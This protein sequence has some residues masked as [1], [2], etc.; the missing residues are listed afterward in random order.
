HHHGA[1]HF[2][3]I[4]PQPHLTPHA[5]TTLNDPTTHWHTTLHKNHPEQRKLLEQVAEYHRT[6]GTELDW[7]ALHEGKGD[8]LTR[9]PGRPFERKSFWISSPRGEGGPVFT[10]NTGSPSRP[11]ET[12]SGV[13]P[14]HPLLGDIDIREGK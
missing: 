3:E 10:K 11:R 14:R 13:F 6:S 1:R 9:V 8:S 5:R 4:G 12:P 7:A 2:W